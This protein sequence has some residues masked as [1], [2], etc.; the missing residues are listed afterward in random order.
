MTEFLESKSKKSKI[1]WLPNA[2]TTLSLFAGFYSIVQAMNNDF[3]NASIA[4]FVAMI[5]DALDGELQD[6]QKLSP[7]L[8][9]SMI[10]YLIWFHLVLHLH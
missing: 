4:I 2:F 3:L 7:H 9:L 10:L 5:F 6:S 1:Y 8:V